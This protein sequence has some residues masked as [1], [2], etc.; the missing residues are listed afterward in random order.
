MLS[1]YQ[2][3]NK[4]HLHQFPLLLSSLLSLFFPK[5]L[6][7]FFLESCFEV[8]RHSISYQHPIF[9]FGGE[10]ITQHILCFKGEDE[11]LIL[12][13]RSVFGGR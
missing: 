4:V 10:G 9:A 11:W 7:S 6:L 13:S 1:F 5:Q 3:L 8:D 2:K 12:K